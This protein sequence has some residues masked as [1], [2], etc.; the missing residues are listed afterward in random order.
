MHYKIIITHRAAK[1]LKK[2]PLKTRRLLIESIDELASE[3][4]PKSCKKLTGYQNYWRI[5][6]GNYRVI[7][8]IEDNQLIITILQTGHRK[9]IYKD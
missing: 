3:P 7:Y 8:A 4:R 1:Q 9:D 5:R 6:S 2:L